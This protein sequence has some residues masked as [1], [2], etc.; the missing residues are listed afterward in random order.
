VGQQIDIIKALIAEHLGG[1]PNDHLYDGLTSIYDLAR[2]CF[3]GTIALREHFRCVPDII[4]FSNRLSYSGEI[5]PL[6]DPG[7]APRPHV[8]EYVADHA[9]ASGRQG[10]T[11]PT[12]ARTITA[13][14]KAITEC[15]TTTARRSAPSPSGRRAGRPDPG[16]GAKL[17]VRRA[18]AP[19][20]RCRK[21]A[22]FQSDERRVVF[23]SMVDSPAGAPL[24]IRREPLFKQRYNVAASRARDQL[25]LVHSL[26]PRRDLQPGDLRAALIEHVRDPGA[27]RRALQDAQRRAESPFEMAVMERLVDAGYRVEPQ[28]WVGQYRIDMVVSDGREQVAL[29]CDGD[30]FHGVDEIPLDMARQAVLERAGWRFIRIRGTRFY[31]DPERTMAGVVETLSD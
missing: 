31:R 25:W 12:E 9:G 28:V 10:R 4:E 24:A 23:L 30:R 18:G 19:P 11:N 21:L 26:D 29:E 22:Q 5:R 17:S 20:V 14:V 15:A 8:V 2:Q 1:I 7:T 16:P 3:G 13:L 27:R 6:R